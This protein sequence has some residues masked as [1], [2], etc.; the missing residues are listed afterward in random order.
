MARVKVASF[1]LWGIDGK[2]V[3]GAVDGALSQVGPQAQDVVAVGFQEVWFQRQLAPIIKGW[4]G[5]GATTRA[6][7]GVTCHHLTTPP[8]SRWRCLV[9]E[10]GSAGIPGKLLELG[11]GLATCV[12]G[13]VRDAFF[14]PFR[15]GY[16]PDRFAH[17]G[18]LAVL[19]TPPG[20]S[21]RAVVNTHFHDYS[22][23]AYGGAR[24]TNIEQLAETVRWIE[25]HWRVPCTLIGDFNIDARRCYM[26]PEHCIDR[27]LYRRL[28]TVRKSRNQFWF[29]VNVH[30]NKQQPVPT[31][32]NGTGAIDMHLLASADG[33]SEFE[34]VACAFGTAGNYLSDHKL[35]CSS[36]GE[37]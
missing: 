6:F 26:D 20:L 3:D 37:V 27:N 22:N 36:W 28:L 12:R 16:I 17:K 31:Q 4:V 23:D 1:N 5:P 30:F 35:V 33:K 29:D 32:A 13:P 25:E 34:F 9:P 10:V 24:S 21:P 14:T 15:G 2:C 7:S 8:G 11:S 18:L 19:F